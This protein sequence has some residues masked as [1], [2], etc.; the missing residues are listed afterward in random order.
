MEIIPLT[1]EHR[2]SLIALYRV[3]TA[4]LRRSGIDQ[5]DWIYPNRFTI[6]GDIRKGIVYGIVEQ[7]RVAGA[8]VIDRAS[9][10]SGSGASPGVVPT[11]SIN[12]L[13]VLPDMQGR[14]IGGSLLRF[15]EDFIRSAGGTRIRLE[16]YS[17]N[18]HAFGMYQ[19]AG[20][21]QV[22]ESRYPFRKLPYFVYEKTLLED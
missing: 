7:G 11:W 21:G 4:E 15:G 18:P 10:A 22:G 16:V 19:R 8:V 9:P 17:G 2:K 12:R 14:G 13:A 1:K 6:S 3:V 20:Y 5:W